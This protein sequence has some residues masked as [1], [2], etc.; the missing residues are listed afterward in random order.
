M[1]KLARF[2]TANAEMP[3]SEHEIPAVF[4]SIIMSDT[5]DRF[6]VARV[7]GGRMW[8]WNMHWYCALLDWATHVVKSDESML[9]LPLSE[10]SA[11][12]VG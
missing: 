2:A 11:W 3:E 8:I 12:I 9:G 5:C 10:N 7:F 4:Y 1:T 6:S